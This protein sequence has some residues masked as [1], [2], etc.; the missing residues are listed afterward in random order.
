MSERRGPTLDTRPLE[1]LDGCTAQGEQ[2]G[3]GSWRR[4]ERGAEQSD[5][6][7]LSGR[8]SGLFAIQDL[9]LGRRFGVGGGP[10]GRGHRRSADRLVR[11]ASRLVTGQAAMAGSFGSSDSV[12]GSGP[13]ASAVGIRVLESVL[14]R[15]LVLREEENESW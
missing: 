3:Q 1:G 6:E 10:R 7:R 12:G 14:G 13:A 5:A 11:K 9:D 4:R 15:A 8:S 2:P